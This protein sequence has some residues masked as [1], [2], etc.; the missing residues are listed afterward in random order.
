[1]LNNGS[2]TTRTSAKN[3][4]SASFNRT[5]PALPKINT[6]RVRKRKALAG[7][8]NGKL[9]DRSMKKIPFSAPHKASSQNNAPYSSSS[10]PQHQNHTN[11][12]FLSKESSHCCHPSISCLLASILTAFILTVLLSNVSWIISFITI[13]QQR[14]NLFTISR[15]DGLQMLISQKTK[16]PI[17]IGSGLAQMNRYINGTDDLS[18]ISSEMFRFMINSLPQTAGDTLNDAIEPFF[19]IVYRK[20]KGKYVG[21]SAKD[22]HHHKMVYL[23]SWSPEVTDSGQIVMREI[24][25]PY[26][27]MVGSSRSDLEEQQLDAFG[28]HSLSDSSNILLNFTL[29]SESTSFFGP[30][31]ANSKRGWRNSTVLCVAQ[32]C[33]HYL[34]FYQSAA[35]DSQTEVLYSTSAF[36]EQF[37][38]YK[39]DDLT[40]LVETLTQRIVASSEYL[41]YPTIDI[42]TGT[43]YSMLDYPHE[44]IREAGQMLREEMALG[45]FSADVT[46]HASLGTRFLVDHRRIQD[47]LGLDLTVIH[48]TRLSPIITAP[49]VICITILTLT[50]VLL[51]ITACISCCMNI[52]IVRNIKSLQR[53]MLLVRDMRLSEIRRSMPFMIPFREFLSLRHTFYDVVLPQLNRYRGFLP[54]HILGDSSSS[55]SSSSGSDNESGTESDTGKSTVGWL[56]DPLVVTDA[57]TVLTARSPHNDNLTVFSSVSSKARRPNSAASKLSLSGSESSPHGA[58]PTAPGTAKRHHVSRRKNKYSVGLRYGHITVMV[59]W[60]HNIRKLLKSCSLDDF[61]KQYSMYFQEIN[62]IFRQYKAYLDNFSESIMVVTFKKSRLACD[63]ALRVS[64][65]IVEMNNNLPHSNMAFEYSIGI[66][67]GREW[68]GTI[69]EENLKKRHSFGPVSR[70]AKYLAT[71]PYQNWKLQLWVDEQIQH[72]MEDHFQFRPIMP[73][74][75]SDDHKSTAYQLVRKYVLYDQE[76]MYRV[77]LKED[78]AKNAEF[79]RAYTKFQNKAYGTALILF[80]RLAEENPHDSVINNFIRE[81]SMPHTQETPKNTERTARVADIHPMMTQNDRGLSASRDSDLYI[82]DH[83]PVLSVASK[84]PTSAQKQHEFVAS[85]IDATLSEWEAVV[86][87]KI[88]Q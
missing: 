15:F 82:E 54:T 34:S 57:E 47:Q 50:V 65:K 8:A 71:Q 67:T 7:G 26:I 84:S 36:S 49:I 21:F 88:S 16:L 14:T 48:M 77:K 76:W 75:T 80:E 81:C 70:R 25:E 72:E 6:S 20:G 63:C 44:E 56:Q 11:V 23:Y 43:V 22:I 31:I 28:T 29:S 74:T 55:S 10:T 37:Q 61:V 3:M 38:S 68:Y 45:V 1:M 18:Y 46:Y 86:G 27:S 58:A 87:N 60:F 62:L 9:S 51:T 33:A 2:S 59:L 79:V 40:F 17:A 32:N 42:N 41:T 4:L 83:S 53:N 69:G 85:D 39:G 73:F 35:H 30:I 19:T 5:K 13:I 52:T 24:G 64:N 66:S 78:K 12:P